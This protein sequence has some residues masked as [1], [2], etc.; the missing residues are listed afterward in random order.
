[1]ECVNNVENRTI[2][3]ERFRWVFCIHHRTLDAE[4]EK[5]G[6][7]GSG[8]EGGGLLNEHKNALCSR[9]FY[10]RVFTC[11]LRFNACH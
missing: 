3:G 6:R 10:A 7:V 9:T 5:K 2:F 1:M 8:G 11:D 4:N